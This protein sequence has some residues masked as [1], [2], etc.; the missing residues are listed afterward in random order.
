MGNL[1]HGDIMTDRKPKV[2]TRD[3]PCTKVD[4]HNCFYHGGQYVNRP[5]IEAKMEIGENAPK[6]LIR[7]G[8]VVLRTIGQVD[9]YCV[10]P[11]GDQWLRTGI[12][13]YLELHPERLEDCTFPPPGVKHAQTVA[14]KAAAKAAKASAKPVPVAPR[15]IIRR[16]RT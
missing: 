4:L 5:V 12:V 11:K 14:K 6:Y 10:T 13:R 8:L 7:E 2:F 16:T 15:R 9:M 3:N 1:L